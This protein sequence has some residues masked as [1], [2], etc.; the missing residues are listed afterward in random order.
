MFPKGQLICSYDTDEYCKGRYPSRKVDADRYCPH[1][2]YYYFN[3]KSNQVR[4]IR[5]KSEVW[6]CDYEAGFPW[7]RRIR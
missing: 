3:K 2:E 4:R 7:M 1:G 6:A 5:N